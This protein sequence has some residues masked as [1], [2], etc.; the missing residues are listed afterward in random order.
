M[1]R[2]INGLLGAA[3]ALVGAGLVALGFSAIGE[4]VKS[5]NVPEKSES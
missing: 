3:T 5:T 1:S 4:A 2:L